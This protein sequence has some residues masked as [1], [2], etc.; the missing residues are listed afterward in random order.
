[1]DMPQIPSLGDDSVYSPHFL[2]KNDTIV[3]L[4]REKEEREEW[5]EAFLKTGDEEVSKA[6]ISLLKINKKR[7]TWSCSHC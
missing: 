3:L 6:Y 1:M 5:D 7:S 2:E 4:S